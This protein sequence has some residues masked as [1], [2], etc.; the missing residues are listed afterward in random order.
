[1]AQSRH[2]GT[3]SDD[4]AIGADSIIQGLAEQPLL[5]PRISCSYTGGLISIDEQ[6]EE[7]LGLAKALGSAG[8]Y[9][10]YIKSLSLIQV[11][12]LGKAEIRRAMR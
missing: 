2:R 6:R 3:G 9:T 10:S 5:C 8:G 11:G 7:S 4:L 12:G 1:M